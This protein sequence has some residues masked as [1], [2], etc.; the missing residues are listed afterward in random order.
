MYYQIKELKMP[1]TRADLEFATPEE[2]EKYLTN[3]F[4]DEGYEVVLPASDKKG[5]EFELRQRSQTIAVQVKY[6]TGKCN[7]AQI[8]KF[9][10]YLGTTE[11]EAALH[12]RLVYRA[13]WI[14]LNRLSMGHG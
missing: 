12:R 9:L 8:E 3:K 10:H 7:I 6:Y 14:R 4:Q 1:K 2:F 13:E 5:Y 11:A